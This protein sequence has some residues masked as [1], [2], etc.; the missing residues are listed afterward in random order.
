MADSRLPA[1][2]SAR[3]KRPVYSV[4]WIMR[5]DLKER[6]DSYAQNGVVLVC[7]PAGYGKTCFLSSWAETHKEPVCWVT[8]DFDA[9]NPI[10][11]WSYVISAIAF[12]YKSFPKSRLLETL[13]SHPQP[14]FLA[15]FIAALEEMPRGTVLIIDDYHQ[16]ENDELQTAVRY[17]CRNLPMGVGLVF[18][19][20]S[21]LPFSMAQLAA[22]ERFKI[23]T[24]KDLAFERGDIRQLA[25]EKGLKL[26]AQEIDT[27][28][29]KTEGWPLCVSL[30]LITLTSEGHTGAH[31]ESVLSQSSILCEPL[32]EEVLEKLDDRLREFVL[33]TSV[34]P[35]LSA[36]SCRPL[37]SAAGMIDYWPEAMLSEVWNNRE[38]LF[39]SQIS[40]GLY[41]CHSLVRKVLTAK[42]RAERPMLYETLCKAAETTLAER[43]DIVSAI[44]V[45]LKRGDKQHA[46]ELI[47]ANYSA[48]VMQGEAY[49]LNFW[50]D[51]LPKELYS[52]YPRL[53]LVK[54][55]ALFPGGNVKEAEKHL[56]LAD[57]ELA[58][59]KDGSIANREIAALRA[60][61]Y[62]M[63]QFDSRESLVYTEEIQSE[64]SAQDSSDLQISA[65]LA[66]GVVHLLQSDPVRAEKD[67]QKVVS[68][69]LDAQSVF[70]SFFGK[71]Y[72]AI[73]EQKKGHLRKAERLLKDALSAAQDEEGNERS[74]AGIA[75]ISLARIYYEW[76]R[77]DDCLQHVRRGLEL[78]GG[79]SLPSNVS[80]GYQT[81]ELVSKLRGDMETALDAS[82]KA[83]HLSS[84]RAA[85]PYIT[86]EALSSL[87]EKMQSIQMDDTL[88]WAN[89]YLQKLNEEPSIQGEAL[90]QAPAALHLSIA[91]GESGNTDDLLDKLLQS[92]S[93]VGFYQQVIET[94]ILRALLLSEQGRE[95]EA[96]LA[97]GDALEFAQ[98]E[99]Y[100]RVF[101]DE[102]EPMRR[103]LEEAKQKNIVPTYTAQLLRAFGEREFR[104]TPEPVQEMLS[105]RE[106]EVL[107][108]LAEGNSPKRIAEKL[109]ISVGTT[110]CHLHRIY[111][112]LGA[113]NQLQAV[114]IAKEKN[115]I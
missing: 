92:S 107:Q 89:E 20:R 83:Y 88:R 40:D 14:D 67:L 100:M 39:I 7:A 97:L 66:N 108:L 36:D 71:Y 32:V 53:H 12:A 72:L 43:G 57:Q 55:W 1:L 106:T 79:W 33:V 87:R 101:L 74:I 63:L 60:L 31:L 103:M 64:S 77:I 54:A 96:L 62:A 114:Q 45:T 3:Y 50:L 19:S 99:G 80:S 112:K 104:P 49:L 30:T 8:L 73:L 81:L 47:L 44:D 111:E 34:L 90:W 78:S 115:I 48:M 52:E 5:Q 37:L 86:H 69:P 46:A 15:E 38:A 9:N 24:E 2:I 23:I 6:M 94:Q 26:N 113:A 10:R 29:R 59:E 21:R 70:L 76:N 42:L 27:I 105:P 109:Y 85:T 18:S 41:R 25:L 68:S 58:N 22:K 65:W 51:Q 110:R 91:S 11:F 17:L 95:N 84:E 28:W 82:Q 98:Y 93:R 13:S 102:G 75:H 56:K 35:Y 16:I 4:N 61:N